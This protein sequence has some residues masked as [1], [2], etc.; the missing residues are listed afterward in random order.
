MKA[1][2]SVDGFG[3]GLGGAVPGERWV[4]RSRLPDGSATDVIG[5][6]DDAGPDSVRVSTA[7]G[8][9]ADVGRD[10]VIAARRAPAA[11]GGGNPLR[12]SADSLEHQALTA[13][14]AAHH[15]PLG[16]WTLR[17]GGGFTSRANSCL[18]VGE[19]GCSVSEAADAVVTWSRSHGIQPRAQVIVGSDPDRAL[20]DLGWRQVGS[21][22]AVL[23]SRLST[24][25]GFGLPDPAVLVSEELDP[26]WLAAYRHSRPDYPDSRLLRTI[27]TGHPPRAFASI[28]RL[29]QETPEPAGIAR[30]HLNAPWLGLGSIWVSPGHRRRGLA[31]AMMHALGHWAARR[32]GR[33]AYLQVLSDNTAAVAAYERLGFR[34]HHTYRYLTPAG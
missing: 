7:P 8:T 25:L 18:A 15:Q 33:F 10:T 21:T 28:G 20:S 31:T 19:P 11:P 22:T 14:L 27:L 24:F 1:P 12:Q 17:A 9:T 30:G 4:I 2:H 32:G 6:I 29:D 34:F 5:W 13:W 23:V 16:E 26:E 3:S